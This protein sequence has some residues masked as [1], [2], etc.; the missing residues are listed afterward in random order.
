V[1]T[2]EYNFTIFIAENLSATDYLN[3]II[4]LNDSICIRNSRQSLITYDWIPPRHRQ[5]LFLVEWTNEYG[6][7]AKMEYLYRQQHDKQANKSIPEIDNSQN[8]FHSFRPF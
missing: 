5:I 7:T 3:V 6:E 8:D 2:G 4:D 1:T